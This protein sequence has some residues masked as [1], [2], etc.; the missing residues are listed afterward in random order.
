MS[1]FQE[2]LWL[3]HVPAAAVIHEEQALPILT[4]CI[5]YIGDYNYYSK[6]QLKTEYSSFFVNDYQI[7]EKE[8]YRTTIK[9][10]Y[11]IELAINQGLV[12]LVVRTV[13][14]EYFMNQKFRDSQRKYGIAWLSSVR[15]VKFRIKFFLTNATLQ[16]ML[17]LF[18]L[19]FYRGY[20]LKSS[21]YGLYTLG[22]TR[23]TRFRLFYEILKHEDEIVSNCKLL[24]YSETIVKFCTHRPSRSESQQQRKI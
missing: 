9:C 8:I 14:D 16:N 20:R 7:Q 17:N 4:G 11:T 1:K 19:F 22:Y 12:S 2:K 24:C 15:A 18:N 5:K 21:P 13:K 3:I 10:S 23:V 6:S